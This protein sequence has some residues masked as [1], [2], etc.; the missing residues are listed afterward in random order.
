M[1]VEYNAKSIF[2]EEPLDTQKCVRILLL[3]IKARFGSLGN[4][5]FTAV[6]LLFKRFI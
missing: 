1:D 2:E 3:F 6:P 4:R 5:C